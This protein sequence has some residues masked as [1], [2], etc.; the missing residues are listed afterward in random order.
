MSEQGVCIYD[1]YLGARCPA[2]T[3]EF[4][5]RTPGVILSHTVHNAMDEVEGELLCVFRSW[6][7]IWHRVF[8][9]VT[10]DN[11]DEQALTIVEYHRF[12]YDH[13]HEMFIIDCLASTSSVAPPRESVEYVVEGAHM[14]ARRCLGTA[15]EHDYNRFS[16]YSEVTRC[17]YNAIRGE[18]PYNPACNMWLVMTR[19]HVRPSEL[20]RLWDYAN[21]RLDDSEDNADRTF[22]DVDFGTSVARRFD[23]V[24]AGRM[25]SNE[26]AYA[27]TPKRTGQKRE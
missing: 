18:R 27:I 4:P 15:P 19:G 8:R 7:N 12:L 10:F 26:L 5:P 9:P 11:K 3:L 17:M 16:W 13:P 20:D 2:P 6:R 22:W 23:T 14:F 25:L 21:G 1:Q 24:S